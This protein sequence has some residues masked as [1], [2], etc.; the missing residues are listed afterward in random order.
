MRDLNVEYVIDDLGFAVKRDKVFCVGTIGEEDEGKTFTFSVVSDQGG[1]AVLKFNSLDNAKEAR[2]DLLFF[3][4][5]MMMQ[6][7]RAQQGCGGGGCPGCSGGDT[8]V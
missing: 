4:T 7:Q 1:R 5:N 2:G 6:Q 3:V 8:E